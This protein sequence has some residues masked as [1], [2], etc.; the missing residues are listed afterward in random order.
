MSKYAGEVTQVTSP[1][2]LVW[3]YWFGIKA[4]KRIYLVAPFGSLNTWE[5]S[6][7]KEVKEFISGH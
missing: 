7:V 1:S 3:E 4:G 5:F 2:G 6:S